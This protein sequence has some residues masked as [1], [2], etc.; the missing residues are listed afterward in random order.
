VLLLLGSSILGALLLLLDAPLWLYY[1]APVL[2]IPVLLV[3]LRMREKGE[4][5]PPS[6]RGDTDDFDSI[7]PPGGG[8]VVREQ[9]GELVAMLLAADRSELF[10]A[11]LLLAVVIAAIFVP[12]GTAT[13]PSPLIPIASVMVS[14]LATGLFAAYLRSHRRHIHGDDHVH[15]AHRPGRA[16]R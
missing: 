8:G 13:E 15:A 14:L 6:K 5:E 12:A 2:G 10:S 7:D 11:T 3:L 4:P 16:H 9:A 1:V